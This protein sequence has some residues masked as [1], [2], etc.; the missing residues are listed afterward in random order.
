MTIPLVF[1]AF[2]WE[3][4]DQSFKYGENEYIIYCFGTRGTGEKVSL[5]IK[6]F[7]PYFFIKVDN[8]TNSPSWEEEFIEKIGSELSKGR[9]NRTEANCEIEVVSGMMDAFTYQEH[10]KTDFYKVSFFTL[11]EYQ[12]A[13][14]IAKEKNWRTYQSGI[15]NM[16]KFINDRNFKYCGWYQVDKYQS[17]SWKWSEHI[18]CYEVDMTKIK[19][20]EKDSIAP[21]I[22]ASFDI[23][24]YSHD[25]Q[26]PSPS[27]QDNAI[28][29][30]ATVFKRYGD[31]DFFKKHVVVLAD[32]E[33][34]QS[35]CA[36]PSGIEDTEVVVVKTEAQLL[37]KWSE[38]IGR[39][40]P[41]IIYSYN[42]DKFDWD[43]VY[44]RA[45]K[46]LRKGDT[47]RYIKK[48]EFET[49][50][51][52]KF[53]I[54]SNNLSRIVYKSGSSY[55]YWKTM[56]IRDTTKRFESS[57]YGVEVFH[58]M[59]LP[60][61]LNFDILIY[62]KRTY[63]LP[64]YT[65]NAVSKNFL[66]ES[67][68]DLPAKKIFEN[69]K[70]GKPADTPQ[71]MDKLLEIA[72]YCV[73]DTLLPQKLVDKMLILESVVEMANC[74]HV[75]LSFLQERGQQIKCLSQ[76]IRFAN[77]K[78]FLVPDG[79]DFDDHSEESY[80]GA[81]VLEPTPGYY[82]YV[83]TLDFASLYPSIIMAHKLCYTTLVRRP[84]LYSNPEVIEEFKWEERSFKVTGSCKAIVKASGKICEK[85][86]KHGDYCGVHSKGHEDLEPSG[87]WTVKT[88][89]TRFA[90]DCQSTILPELLDTLYKERKAIKRQM[91][92]ADNPTL[93]NI[94]DKRQLAVK[95]SMNSIYGFTAANV[96][97]AKEIAQTITS[98][99]RKMIEACKE[100]TMTKLQD[101]L[102]A[103]YRLNVVAGD[104]DSIFIHFAP[105]DRMDM[106]RPSRLKE[107]M[108]LATLAADAMSQEL[109]KKPIKLEFEKVYCPLIIFKKKRYVGALFTK[110][111]KYDK[112]DKKGVISKRRDNCELARKIYETITKIMMHASNL[113]EGIDLCFKEIL[114]TIHQ[115]K[116][117]EIPI[118]EL[119]I[120]KLLKDEYKSVQAHKKL[121]DRLRDEGFEIQYVSGDRIPFI[122]GKPCD[123]EDNNVDK[124]KALDVVVHPTE[125]DNVKFEVDVL[126]YV[127]KQLEKPIL[128]FFKDLAPQEAIGLFQ[129]IYK[130]VFQ[131]P[132]MKVKMPE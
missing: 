56:Y 86:V 120:T 12:A 59:V 21:F 25:G 61:R 13:K 107:I 27:D 35:S 42:G 110:P 76:I 43:Y 93:K 33:F 63:Q 79:T 112:I 122:F 87:E 119:E 65:L 18:K 37:L 70:L 104:T 97:P 106:D 8:E 4:K 105:L 82:E 39:M 115:M 44:V 78:G 45:I 125:I 29:Q 5:A 103:Q 40:D 54:F 117:G 68:F 14:R 92:K 11:R 6:G 71:Q 101:Q 66:K 132:K 28:I 48:E 89:V 72:R 26:F 95:V 100:Y 53:T 123:S 15:D 126:Y 113:D 20:I 130:D 60:G 83:A 88:Q 96:L 102:Q 124:K 9:Q 38:M 75:P 121:A 32:K 24:V 19:M 80:K 85:P 22:Q 30:I 57:A 74:T 51:K 118:E 84:E 36:S 46:V 131:Q 94:L 55:D 129:G 69:Y 98:T 50:E 49:P 2:S 111:E 81:T 7:K 73:Q 1:Q 3:E 52:A 17:S 116:A 109:F 31:T 23:E 108:S 91:A 99:G 77:A 64:S 90:T 127:R 114:Q 67:K 62:I 34:D 41:D 128:S 58:R 10:K 16:M 47:N